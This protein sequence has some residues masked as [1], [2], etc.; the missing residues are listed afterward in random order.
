MKVAHPE[1]RLQGCQIFPK[2]YQ[3]GENIPN[4]HKKYQM[5]MKYTKWP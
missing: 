3:N 2:K 1:D 4:D 5:A